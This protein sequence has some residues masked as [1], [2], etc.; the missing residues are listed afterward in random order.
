MLC[1]GP[2]FVFGVLSAVNGEKDA[3]NLLYMFK[4]LPKFFNL[5][6]LGHLADDAFE[7]VS[8]YFPVDY[9]VCKNSI[10]GIFIILLILFLYYG[11]TDVEVIYLN[12]DHLL[13]YG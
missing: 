13:G 11:N 1:L 5:F 3:V 7:V 8:C 12:Q 4:N 2:D 9:E 10:T 6:P